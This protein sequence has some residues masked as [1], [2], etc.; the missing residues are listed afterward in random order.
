MA[1]ETVQ[2]SAE[3]SKALKDLGN[4]KLS[5]WKTTLR[6]A[7]RD[8]MKAVMV[9]AKANLASISPGKTPVHRTY[10]GNWVGAGFAAR[11]VLMKVKLIPSRGAVVA[12]LGV[13]REAFYAVSFFEI[14][15]PSRGIPRNPWLT[16]AMESSKD[17][18]IREVGAAMRKRIDAIARKNMRKAVKGSK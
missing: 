11:N 6:A 18:T 9:Q 14:G 3:L 17:K 5:E 13:A 4:M 16:S 1:G 8:P 15:V 10:L 12:I 7:V 2:G